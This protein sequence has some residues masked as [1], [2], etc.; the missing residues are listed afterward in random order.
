MASQKIAV[1]LAT[2]VVGNWKET[3]QWIPIY[4]AFATIALAFSVG[5]NNLPAPFSASVGTGALTLLKASIM[6][7]AIYVPGAASASNSTTVNALFFNFLKESQPTEGFLMWSMVVVLLTAT[8]WLAL[9]THLELPVSSLQSIQGA[10]LGTMLVAKGFDYLPLWNKNDNHNFNGGG[11]LWIFLEWTFAPS[12][13]CLCACFLFAVLKGSLL[14]PENA[15]KRILIFLPID[16]GISAGLLCFFIISQ[17]IGN[18]VD[19]N[20]LT[21][22]IAVA[23]SASIGALLSLVVVV[24]LAMKKLATIQNHRNSKENTSNI[25]ESVECQETQGQSSGVKLDD[26]DV[27]EMLKDFMRRRVLDT[28]YEEEERCWASLD[29]I[30]EPDQVQPVSQCSAN[31]GVEQPAPFKQLL[32]STPNRLVQ[33]RNFQRM[34]KTTPIENVIKFMRNMAKSTFSPVLEYDRRTLIRHALAEKY[35]EI[36]DCFCFPQLLASCIFALIQSATEIAAIV[37][38]YVAILDVFNHRSKYSVNGEDVGHLQVKWWFRGIGG[39]VAAMG[40][41]LCGWRLTQCLGGKLTYISNSRGWASQLSTVAAMIIVSRVKLPVSSVHTFV[42]SLIGLGIADDHRN[43]NW[44]LLCKIL[45]GWIMT[46]IFC[47]G[48][49]YLIFSASIH[50]PAYAVP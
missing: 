31:T 49:A 1:E 24:P 18:Y 36:E 5:A 41:L 9:A 42:G 16:Y 3:Y 33:T 2:R 39:L 12:I 6:A 45:C 8:M 19:V 43:V 38:P 23:G 40:F 4:G 32:K 37:N 25:H 7:S 29:V 47:C 13:A 35:D 27:D 15:E 22:L 21:V 14:R 17:V 11:L 44:K 20:R 46:I 48:V 28:V 30:Q 50:T 34:E 26:D 10:M